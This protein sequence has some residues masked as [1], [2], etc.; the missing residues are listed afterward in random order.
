[1]VDFCNF[2]RRNNIYHDKPR[3][4]WQRYLIYSAG[5]FT[6]VIISI[7]ILRDTTPVQFSPPSLEDML[8]PRGEMASRSQL[9]N[10]HWRVSIRHASK[11]L[12]EVCQT[13]E[14]TVLTHKNIIMDGIPMKYSYIYLCRPFGNIQAVVNARKVVS[15]NAIKSVTCIET[16]GNKTKHVVRKYPFSLK[17]ISS[18]TF[19]PQTRVVRKAEEACTWLHAIDIVDSI[20]D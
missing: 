8:K 17:Y 3:P 9:D 16:Y 4:R 20:W 15:D 11:A 5:F 1:M 6:I 13:H 12:A 18:Q 7:W 14:Y 19:Q 10:V 2:N